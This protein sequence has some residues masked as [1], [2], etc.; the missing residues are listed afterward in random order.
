MSVVPLDHNKIA[1]AG[2]A[3]RTNTRGWVIYRNPETGRW[4]TRVEALD[5]IEG[6]VAP[7]PPD[8]AGEAGPSGN[9]RR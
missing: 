8:D 2:W 9:H 6:R 5:I 7:L 1:T 3:Y 4:H